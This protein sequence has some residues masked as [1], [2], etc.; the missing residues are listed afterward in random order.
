MA[1]GASQCN[2]NVLRVLLLSRCRIDCVNMRVYVYAWLRV[3]VL[4]RLGLKNALFA[5]MCLA[6]SRHLQPHH[7]HGTTLRPTPEPQL[8]MRSYVVVDGILRQ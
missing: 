8:V 3:C 5:Q 7:V 4:A 1:R 2:C 6:A